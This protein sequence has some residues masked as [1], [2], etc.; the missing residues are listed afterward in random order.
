M[1]RITITCPVHSN[2][3]NAMFTKWFIKRAFPFFRWKKAGSCV[4]VF[5]SLHLLW[6]SNEIHNRDIT[7]TEWWEKCGSM[8]STSFKLGN[9]RNLITIPKIPIH[10]LGGEVTCMVVHL[11][12]YQMNFRRYE[13]IIDVK[14]N[15]EGCSMF[16]SSIYPIKAINLPLT[17]H[18]LT[19]IVRRR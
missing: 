9:S 10:K 6:Q 19:L 16:M 4:Y 1:E 13:F 15:H 12:A 3:N 18:T 14:T 2:T 7:L 17:K 11:N 5:V 8:C